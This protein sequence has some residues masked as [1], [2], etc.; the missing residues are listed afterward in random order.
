VGAVSLL[1]TGGAFLL[2]FALWAGLVGSW[3]WAL[4]DVAKTPDAQFRAAG[5]EKVVWV[6]I[7]ALASFVGALIWW[8]GKRNDVRRFAG[9]TP[10][11]PAGW[12][13][14]GFA[15]ALRYWDGTAWTEHRHAAPQ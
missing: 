10:P 7:V 4:V 2:F 15:G 3:I 14:D 6:L 8:F 12:Y 11:P 13:P 5:T 1:F 9:Y